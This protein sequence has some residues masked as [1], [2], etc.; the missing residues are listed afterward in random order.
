MLLVVKTFEAAKSPQKA[1][2]QASISGNI[3]YKQ[4]L[5]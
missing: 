4:F 3:Y 5:T 2:T 1:T